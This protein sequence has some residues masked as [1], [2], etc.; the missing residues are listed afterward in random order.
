MDFTRSNFP[1]N[2][3]KMSVEF[4]LFPIHCSKLVNVEFHLHHRSWSIKSFLL[5]LFLGISVH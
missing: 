1:I 2:Y 5:K 4:T 3:D